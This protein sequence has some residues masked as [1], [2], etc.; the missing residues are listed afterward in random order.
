MS[1]LH[2]VSRPNRLRD[3]LARAMAGDSVLLIQEGVLADFDS[4]NLESIPAMT[5]HALSEHITPVEGKSGPWR[6]RIER[7]DFSGFVRLTERHQ[8]TIFWG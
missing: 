8:T 5:V 1:V 7:I 6:K 3:C 4:V 2:V